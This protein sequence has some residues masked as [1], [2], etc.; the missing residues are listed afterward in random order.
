MAYPKGAFTF[1]KDI[2]M[3]EAITSQQMGILQFVA[4]NPGISREKLVELKGA[5]DADIKYLEGHDLIRERE[6]H[7]Y[8]VSHFGEMALRRGL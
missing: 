7:H 2:F 4:K 1:Q 5:T 6:V 8:R 3:A